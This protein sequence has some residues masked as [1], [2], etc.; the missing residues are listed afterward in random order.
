M[1]KPEKPI[2]KYKTIKE[3]YNDLTYHCSPNIKEKYL[4]ACHRCSGHGKIK[5]PKDRCPVEGYKWDA[6]Y[7]PC[8]LCGGSGQLNREYYE[9]KFK[10]YLTN[11][12]NSLQL[13][14]REKKLY[15]S[16][17]SKI[18][19]EEWEWLCETFEQRISNQSW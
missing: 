5:D 11:Y 19:K 15:E 4:W 12:E 17:R 9:E 14:H 16:I 7:I 13:Y 2:K 18:S 10:E 3:L 8:P 1:L 6:D